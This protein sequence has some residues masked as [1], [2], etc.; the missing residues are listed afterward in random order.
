[1]KFLAL[2]SD[3]PNTTSEDF[4]PLREPEKDQVYKLIEQGLI[5]EIYFRAERDDAVLILECENRDEAE[6]CLESLPMVKS[7]LLQYELIGLRNY[8]SR[9]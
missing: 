8:P 4:A 5:K 2:M 3:T 6:N 1:M 9:S 7:R